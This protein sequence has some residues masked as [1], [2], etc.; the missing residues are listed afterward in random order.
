MKKVTRNEVDFS[1]IFYY[2]EAKF[3]IDWNRANDMFF[4]NSLDYKSHNEYEL[5][6][7]LEYIDKDKP[8]EELSEADKGYY[9]INQFMVD[10]NV[11]SIWIDNN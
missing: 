6:E 1:E 4:H 2:A 9:I 8:F 10:N 3:N 7:P 11:N 5:N